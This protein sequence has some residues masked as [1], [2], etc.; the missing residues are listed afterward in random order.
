MG[1]LITIDGSYGESG[2]QILRTALSLSTLLQKPVKII[3]IRQKRPKPG[4][5]PQHLMGVLAL[6]E[7][8]QAKVKG[9]E[10]D[11]Q[12]LEFYP[13]KISG[14]EFLFDVKT[15]GSITLILQTLIIPLALAAKTSKVI[16]KGGTHVPFSPPFDYFSEVFLPFLKRI[17]IE[18]EIYLRKWGFYPRGGGEIIF[19]IIPCQ[20]FYP[21]NLINRGE[22]KKI[23]IHS[24]CSNLDKS[25]AQRQLKGAKQTLKSFFR[26]ETPDF[27]ESKG[28]RIEEKVEVVKSLDKNTFIFILGQYENSTVGFSGL[29]QYGK[30]AEIIGEEVAKEF[31]EFHQSNS[32]IDYHLADQ[33]IPFMALANGESSYTTNIFSNHTKTNIWVTE[34]FLPVKFQIKNIDKKIVNISVKGIGIKISNS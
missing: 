10:K 4:L 3:N 7:I 30:K 32:A 34:Q 18:T 13:G 1:S 15:A 17:G 28:F 11:S 9:A 21:I 26:F 33:L 23:K 19:K 5:Q 31:L 29:G 25:I 24:I 2:G 20:S 8:C 27:L 16:L 6:A 14:G 22:L 12:I